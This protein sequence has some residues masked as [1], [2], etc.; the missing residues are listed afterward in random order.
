MNV[1]P[2]GKVRLLV[3][4]K[5]QDIILHRSRKFVVEKKREAASTAVLKED[6]KYSWTDISKMIYE[7]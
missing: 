3:F 7:W 5:I 1:I 6:T 2:C 4:F